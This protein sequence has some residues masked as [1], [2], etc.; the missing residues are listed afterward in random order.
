MRKKVLLFLLLL[1]GIA[2]MV[3]AQEHSENG[4][5]FLE[6]KSLEYG[7]SFRTWNKKNAEG[8]RDAWFLRGS[9]G[10]LATNAP[11]LP[12]TLTANVEV[13]YK[14]Q[15]VELSWN[16]THCTL[17]IGTEKPA[18]FFP[19][20]LP[21]ATPSS[22][23]LYSYSMPALSNSFSDHWCLSLHLPIA[24]VPVFVKYG[25][26]IQQPF[27]SNIS[28]QTNYLEDGSKRRQTGLGPLPL[29]NTTSFSSLFALGFSNG[30]FFCSFDLFPHLRNNGT[31]GAHQL[32]AGMQL[33]SG[34]TT[35]AP[36]W[37]PIATPVTIPRSRWGI[38]YYFQ[39]LLGRHLASSNGLEL[40]WAK[41][42]SD[43]WE[44]Q[45][46]W[47]YSHQGQGLQ[48]ETPSVADILQDPNG[49]RYLGNPL[50][51]LRRARWTIQY[52]TK[53]DQAVHFT[54]SGGLGWH[55][56]NYSLLEMLRFPEFRPVFAHY[57][58]I[59]AGGGIRFRYFYSQLQLNKVL[60]SS[61]PFFLEWSTGVQL[62][63]GRH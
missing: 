45:L 49:F 33:T 16:H 38:A 31:M 40:T 53:P 59:H 36:T 35:V 27:T 43:Q 4:V 14:W 63:L 44:T 23:V 42:L 32:R 60:D 61:F 57:A 25:V 13:G 11:Q 5:F 48:K 55:F 29:I 24:A 62:Q 15:I 22:T 12:A 56:S 20:T 3:E 6:R 34:K 41:T 39:I 2:N 9:L 7:Q 10:Y 52:A 28:V 46:G 8:H 17:P 21:S 51:E 47:Q 50:S 26:G 37:Y 54:M 1:S 58:G 18:L 19:F 30:P